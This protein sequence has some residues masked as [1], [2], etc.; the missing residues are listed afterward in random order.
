MIYPP[1]H[2]IGIFETPLYKNVAFSRA[3]YTT[4]CHF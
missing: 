2:K 3:P 1:R 4:K